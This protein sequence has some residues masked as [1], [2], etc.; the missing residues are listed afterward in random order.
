M[1]YLICLQAHSISSGVKINFSVDFIATAYT[2]QLSTRLTINRTQCIQQRD[3]R[4]HTH[5]KD[6]SNVLQLVTPHRFSNMQGKRVN[7]NVIFNLPV[8]RCSLNNFEIYATLC[9]LYSSTVR[10]PELKHQCQLKL[11]LN[12][13]LTKFRFFLL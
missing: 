9:I 2:L 5:R 4:Y 3:V 1:V 12:L 7:K 6:F 13:E 11:C 10:G 8:S